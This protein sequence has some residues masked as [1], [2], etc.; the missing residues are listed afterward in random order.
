M[1]ENFISVIIPVYNMEHLVRECIESVLNQTYKN[2]EII[3]VNDF[4]TDKSSEICKSLEQKYENV[5]FVEQEFNQGPLAARVRGIKESKG[6]YIVFCDADDML[7]ENCIESLV[8]GHR[9]MKTDLV[10]GNFAQKYKDKI[11]DNKNRL[12]VGVYET[13]ALLERQIDDGSMSGI[14]IS[15]QCGKLYKR[16][17]IDKFVNH[18]PLNVRIN[19]DGIFNTNYLLNSATV[20]VISNRVYI[21]RT[22]KRTSK[23]QV[24]L[25]L[26]TASNEALMEMREQWPDKRSFDK[27]MKRRKVS[28]TFILSF[29]VCNHAG[30]IKARKQ[31]RV[32]WKELEFR[33]IQDAIQEEN[34]RIYKRVFFKLM[35]HKCYLLFYAGIRIS[36]LIR[37]YVAR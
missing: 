16:S 26:F 29:W 17:I 21:E 9:G 11:I 24:N 13:N 23:K 37:K 7:P 14:L 15:S 27:Q 6:D 28:T 1:N 30:F 10:I 5:H 20:G 18:L 36:P 8:T 4:S 32:L 12:A 22:R 33:K 2:I 19:E 31:L 3:M 35:K 25:N 34:M